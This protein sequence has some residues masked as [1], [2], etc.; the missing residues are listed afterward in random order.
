MLENEQEF[1]AHLKNVLEIT[2]SQQVECVIVGGIALRAAMD[3]PVEFQRS[4]GTIPDID[5]IGLGPNPQKIK[6]AQIEIQNYR[7]SYPNCPA[8]GL[9]AVTFSDQ[10]K[11][12]SSPFELLSGLR[13]NN[14]GEYS[15]TFRRIDKPISSQTMV[16]LNHQYGS[17]LIPT[18]P[19]ETVY[20]RYFTRMGYLKPK[21]IEKI[22]EFA[23]FIKG[24]GN[25][26]LD[27]SLYETYIEF[28]QR[29]NKEYPLAVKIT[30]LYWDFD[31]AIGGRVSGSNGFIYKMINLFHR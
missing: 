15:L 28:C 9:E 4:N 5:M 20:Y 21:D 17:T 27:S 8:V 6:Q 2:R 13:K 10:S 14:N 24:K 16:V 19:D 12:K 18:F 7:K 22:G 31:N 25:N 23:C 30:K 1:V 29:I 3:K 11:T 26:T